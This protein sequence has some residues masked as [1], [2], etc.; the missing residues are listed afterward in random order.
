V[1]RWQA[2]VAVWSRERA[3][4]RDKYHRNKS[5]AKLDEMAKQKKKYRDENPEKA[6]AC[7]RKCRWEHRDERL[8][9]CKAWSKAHRAETT[10]KMQKRRHED[11]LYALT[12]RLR[13]RL[14]GFLS[15][16]SHWKKD[17]SVL[18]QLGCTT[19]ELRERLECE[20]GGSF[21]GMHIDHVFPFAA[22][23][24]EMEGWQDRVCH[25]TNMQALTKNENLE[26]SSRL[27]TKAMAAK[28]ARWAWPDGV[29]EADLPDRYDG[30]STA[31]R[32]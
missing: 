28:V 2:R 31:L 8:A 12:V 24:P 18:K 29:T 4:Q 23:S 26:K 3:R 17:G 14:T 32:K 30:W 1:S 27:P 22:Y 11:P 13:N 20:A 25:N 16:R 21:D 7:V 19:G 6:R 9:G 10:I 15:R 5:R